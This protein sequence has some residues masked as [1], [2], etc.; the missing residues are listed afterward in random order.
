MPRFCANISLLFTELPLL[1]RV[2]AAAQ[3]GFGA[4]ELQFPYAHT[5]Q[6]WRERLDAA[7]LPVVLH[8]LPPGDWQAGERG[9]ACL[10][11]RQ[12]EFRDGVEQAIGYA[13]ALGCTQLNCLAGLLPD[14]AD[15]VEADAVLADNLRHADQRLAQAGIRLLVEAINTRDMP[16]FHLHRSH[17]VLDRMTSLGLRNTWLQYDVYHM[18][19]MEGDL[20][21]TLRRHLDRIAHIQIADHPGR[22]EPGT[23]EIHYPF[24]FSL[25][26]ELG[27]DG[28]IG[29]EYVPRAGTLQGLD[30]LRSVEGQRTTDATA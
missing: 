2:A 22:H 29:C 4:I 17:Q 28:W 26:D 30:W 13:Q 5:P 14:G 3:A 24:L 16:G 6:E 10:A 23:G 7:Q 21:G 1:D 19:I 12:Q 27:Y 20:S 9:I 11:G 8:N 25:L 18:Q 15:P